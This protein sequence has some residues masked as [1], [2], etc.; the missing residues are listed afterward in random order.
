MPSCVAGSKMSH[1]TQ[2][3]ITKNF[4]HPIGHFFQAR[5]KRLLFNFELK[6]VEPCK[7]C[8]RS[9]PRFE[10]RHFCHSNRFRSDRADNRVFASNICFWLEAKPEP[11]IRLKSETEKPVNPIETIS[12]HFLLWR[13][14]NRNLKRCKTGCESCS[15]ILDDPC[16]K[17]LS[18]LEYEILD[19]PGSPSQA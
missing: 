13:R 2:E 4:K 10:F 3:W 11:L 16:W 5:R 14:S 9:P 12:G 15:R 17:A 7:K 19:S 18:L 1:T 8:F 6:L